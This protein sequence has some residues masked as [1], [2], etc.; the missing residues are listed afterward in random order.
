MY[1]FL[2]IDCKNNID[3]LTVFRYPKKNVAIVMLRTTIHTIKHDG[4]KSV[5]AMADKDNKVIK[6]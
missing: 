5:L 1:I 4:K 3:S 2:N 6:F